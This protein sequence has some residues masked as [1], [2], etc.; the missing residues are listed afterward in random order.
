MVTIG[1]F[2]GVHQGHCRLIAGLRELASGL[3]RPAVAMSF[4]PHPL[5]VLRSSYAPTRLTWPERK[6]D[7]L[8][9]AGAD[10]VLLCKVTPEFLNL[11]AEEF[12]KQ[13][14]KKQL[15]IAGIV[16]GPNFGF[17]RDRVG[18][19]E[20]LQRMCRQ[21]EM[22]FR[23]VSLA[24]DQ[25][26]VSSSLIRKALAKGDVTAAAEWLGRPHRLAGTVVSGD[27]RGK[28]LGFPTA[29]LDQIAVQVPAPGVYA[30]SVYVAGEAFPGACHI[31]PNPTFAQAA[32]K[33]EVHIIDFEMDLYDKRIEVDFLS[34]LR[35]IRTFEN[36]ESL[37]EQLHSDI[38]KATECWR[39]RPRRHRFSGLEQTVRQWLQLRAMDELP[40]SGTS[41]QSLTIDADGHLHLDWQLGSQMLVSDVH[42]LL[43]SLEEKILS[44]FPML[45]SVRSSAPR[46]VSRRE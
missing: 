44:V 12:F 20:L 29:N 37:K 16:E 42:H 24:G 14:L 21:E 10:E 36:F 5:E 32:N 6:A 4:E 3:R 35:G 27:R 18:D 31:G 30:V 9:Q 34:R 45:Q 25:M 11:T 28:S 7:L 17:G 39:Q 23:L 1:N 2:D 15:G 19:V 41:L 26:P 38:E 33:V 22:E 46:P 40:V 13:I 43:F 8:K